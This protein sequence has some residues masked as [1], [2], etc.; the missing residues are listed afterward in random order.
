M[1]RRRQSE[2]KLL[3]LGKKKGLSGQRK[4]HAADRRVPESAHVNRLQ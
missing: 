1:K 3:E 4:R 2:I